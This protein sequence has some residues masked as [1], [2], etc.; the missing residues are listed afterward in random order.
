MNTRNLNTSGLEPDEE[1][2]NSGRLRKRVAVGTLVCAVMLSTA[3]LTSAPGS[4]APR[5]K[6]K[7]TPTPTATPSPT[8]TAT[9]T[10]TPTPTPTTPPPT[11][12]NPPPAPCESTMHAGVSYCL[13]TLTAIASG[14]HPIGARVAV[15]GAFVLDIAAADVVVLGRDD[16]PPGMFCG[17]TLATLLA[18]FSSAQPTPPLDSSLD[19]YGTVT[20]DLALHVD[21]YTYR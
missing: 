16:C 20:A 9:P 5:V 17:A 15:A 14:K 4:A 1:R 8:P 7:P 12:T 18:D 6:P 11:P 21:A 3:V 13:T 10:P 19:V 2:R